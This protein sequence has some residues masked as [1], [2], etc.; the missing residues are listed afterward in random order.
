[1]VNSPRPRTQKAAQTLYSVSLGGNDL[2]KTDV[3]RVHY[4]SYIVPGRDYSYHVPT[5]DFKLIKES[6]DIVQSELCC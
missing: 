1:M 4:T 6:L 3:L 5:R 2:F